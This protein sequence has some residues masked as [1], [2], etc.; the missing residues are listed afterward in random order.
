MWHTPG[1]SY[2]QATTISALP[3][4]VL[5]EI[6]CFYKEKAENR[7]NYLGNRLVWKWHLLVHVCRGWRQVAFGSRICLDLRILCTPRTPARKDLGIWPSL[8]IVIDT[9]HNGG[10]YHGNLPSSSED[11]MVAAL[12][13]SERVCKIWI[14]TSGLWSEKIVTAMQGT[15]PLL[16]V[17]RILSE[18]GNGPVLPAEFLAPRLQ[19]IMLR[20]IPFPA[21]PTLLLSTGDLVTLH[22]DDIPLSGYISPEAMVAGLAA[23]PRLKD[24]TIRFQ[25][26]APRPNRI[27]PPPI[28]RTLLPA[29]TQFKFRG[30]SE[31][32]E[33]LVSRI[34]APQL[35][36]ISTYYLNQLADIPV[37]QLRM[38]VDRSVGPRSTQLRNAVL[39]FY[40]NLVSFRTYDRTND[41]L[42]GH[43]TTWT[44]IRC[45][46]FDWQTAH[47]AQVLSHLSASLSNAVHLNFEDR[48][49]DSDPELESTDDVEWP[50]FLHQF[51]TAQTLHIPHKL[52][53]YVALALENIASE[54]VAEVLPSLDLIHLAG[55]SALS[56][57]K[58]I[59]ARRLSGRPVTVI[60][61]REEFDK[62]VESYNRK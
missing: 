7:L 50:H 59:A 49:D 2:R 37:T 27:P 61:T 8:P 21:L 23:L 13:H 41:P 18:S 15:F 9:R 31:Y 16:T 45:Q 11:N 19:S 29:L 32:L 60:S 53:G 4:N 34:D 33:D 14:V 44:A 24:F 40:D 62:R 17:L 25:W 28:T 12:E 42:G 47:I 48:L 56:I 1:D 57:E 54:T 26:D 6:F 52:A 35:N 46:G 22:L 20:G 36:K 38:F 39:T 5:L 43:V 58:F 55:Q 10:P 51:S 30:T 3:D